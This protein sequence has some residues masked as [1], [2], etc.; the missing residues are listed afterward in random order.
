MT[1]IDKTAGCCDKTDSE[2][3][4]QTQFTQVLSHANVSQGHPR[5][6]RFGGER[7]DQR[8]QSDNVDVAGLRH[9]ERRLGPAATKYD[10]SPAELGQRRRIRVDRAG[11]VLRSRDAH[12]THAA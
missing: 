12:P 1:E 2:R 5:R 9:V 11:Q 8:I 10:L 6:G 3:G 4:R 7:L